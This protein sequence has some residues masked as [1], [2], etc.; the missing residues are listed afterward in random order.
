LTLIYFSVQAAGLHHFR[1]YL[2][3]IPAQAFERMC[4]SLHEGTQHGAPN[5]IRHETACG[6]RI[7]Q[8]IGLNA[9]QGCP[10]LAAELWFK[11]HKE[12]RYTKPCHS[13]TL[14]KMFQAGKR[15]YVWPETP[16]EGQH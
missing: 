13:G 15:R 12:L 6:L 1:L 16:T 14:T 11:A 4:G 7:S 10:K 2:S 5:K 8:I 9:P 3:Q